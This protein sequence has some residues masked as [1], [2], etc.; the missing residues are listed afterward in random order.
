MSEKSA[1]PM[2]TP[3]PDLSHLTEDER[4]IIENVM[5]RQKKEEEKDVE[6]LKKKQEEVQVLETTI[7]K[8]A[9]E[10]REMGLTFE[11]TCEIC[12]KTKF[13]DGVGHVCHY[14]SVRCCARCGGKVTLRSNKVIWVCILCRKKQEL[15]IKTGQWV[16]SNLNNNEGQSLELS[17]SSEMFIEHSDSKQRQERRPRLEKARST[18]RESIPQ[19][20]LNSL[21]SGSGQSLPGSRRGSLK[22]S[23]SSK[24]R[25]LR[26]QY[27]QEETSQRQNVADR[28]SRRSLEVGDPMLHERGNSVSERRSPSSSD[29]RR[30]RPGSELRDDAADERHHR[31]NI[32]R[33]R[34]MQRDGARS[35]DPSLSPPTRN[36]AELRESELVRSRESSFR[37]RRR[38]TRE[39]RRE[40]IQFSDA[41]NRDEYR[42]RDRS[43]RNGSLERQPQQISESE[44]ECSRDV[45]I[46]R[47][48]S[49]N[50]SHVHDRERRRD[51]ENK[52]RRDSGKAQDL[53][54]PPHQKRFSELEHYVDEIV[55]HPEDTQ[56]R[57]IS[58][59]SRS[60]EEWRKEM[61]G[62]GSTSVSNTDT[63]GRFSSYIRKKGD[64]RNELYS[65]ELSE[66][67]RSKPHKHRR[68]KIQR[69]R[70]SSSSDDEIKTTPDDE[71][72][73]TPEWSSCDDGDVEGVIEQG[74][75]VYSRY[76]SRH[77]ETPL[78]Q[79]KD[80]AIQRGPDCYYS[81][82]DIWDDA[83]SPV[84]KKTV[85]F[86]RDSATSRQNSEELWDEQQTKDSGI[87]TSSSATLNEDNNNK[88]PIAWKSSSDG[89]RMIG[90]MILKKTL[91]EVDGSATSAAILGLKVVGGRFLESG[92]LGALV[93]KVKKGSV[94]D[95]VGH[96][97][98]GDEVLEWNGRSLQGRTYE[99]V[100]DIISESRQDHQVELRVCRPISDIGWTETMAS[101]G[102]SNQEFITLEDVSKHNLQQ[103]WRPSVTVTSPNSPETVR[104]RPHS[105][106]VGG[107]I[108][109]KLW[110]DSQASQLVVTVIC[111]AE[112]RPRVNQLT[113]NPYAKVFLLPDRSEKSKRRTKTIAN[114]NEP[115]WN[116]TFVY[117][118]LRR[119]DLKTRVLEITVWD[120]DRYGAN[121]FL[122]EVVVDLSSTP[123]DNKGQWY[124]LVSH[125]D[126]LNAQLRR[127]GMF[128]DT[129]GGSGTLAD[130][131]SPLSNV[132]SRL[133]DGD[134]S[135]F[136]DGTIVGATPWEELRHDHQRD[137]HY[138]GEDSIPSATRGRPPTII[139]SDRPPYSRRGVDYTSRSLSP[140]NRRSYSP[141]HGSAAVSQ[142]YETHSVEGIPT[143]TPSPK[144]RQL[145]PT[146]A[147][148]QKRG[149]LA[150][151]LEDMA[152]RQL[153]QRV[154]PHRRTGAGRY[155]DGEM[156]PTHSYEKQ[157]HAHPYRGSHARNS[158][159]L[160]GSHSA[161]DKR[162]SRAGQI[163]SPE[164]EGVE[165]DGSETS[166]A[167]KFSLSSAFS[168]QSKSS[169]TLSEFTSRMQGY[170]PVHPPRPGRRGPLVQST[171]IDGESDDKGDG[172]LSDTA[173]GS[174]TERGNMLEQTDRGKS[175]K[176]SKAIQFV[177]LSQKSNSTSQLSAT[178]D[179][180]RRNNSSLTGPLVSHP[181]RPLSKQT[182]GDSVA[183]SVN[184]INS[185]SSQW[186]P[187]LRLTPEGEYSTFV[188]GLG[189]GQ[190]VGRQALA[191]P[192]LGDI[193]L[194]I[195]DRKGNLEVEVIRARGLQPKPGAK[196]LP[197]PY[198]KVYLVQ[199]TKCLS[200]AKTT[201]ARR[202]LDPL[203]QEQLHF[204]E[205]YRGCV[206]QVTVWGDY[207]R[208]EKKVFMG[209]AQIM[210]DD[211]DLSNIV[212]GWYKLFHPASLV[213]LPGNRQGN[214]QCSIDSFG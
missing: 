95:T 41:G 166:S 64:P 72:K 170:G 109:L 94:A 83:G 106:V 183:S 144:K 175:T 76:K 67:T 123:L 3:L 188:E 136:D 100:F 53:K 6:I 14:C 2:V 159:N 132:S 12:L 214:P 111:A 176:G 212:I 105:P 174:I 148:F 4:K 37:N 56:S 124:F 119:S 26:R 122:G 98:P 70:S 25:E 18:D 142:R 34:Q 200:K 79:R 202:T 169:R 19:D 129:D 180:G 125:E 84:H 210:L 57:K 46:E 198:V 80:H 114:T 151:D 32:E 48:R 78:T 77:S 103:D 9:E 172:S 213:N 173:V 145:P 74:E 42:A 39:I 1:P 182:S 51:S 45:P 152:T 23:G 44:R 141:V 113:R 10:Q 49:N 85:R 139:P 116:Q 15:L 110:Y 150:L 184:A 192:N 137:E 190:L 62:F 206:L 81:N 133:S 118:S 120:Y 69:Q 43:S 52:S 102:G 193:Q 135:D 38:G 63:R 134:I 40:D 208:M 29:R 197:A 194:S 201:T 21:H 185:W 82:Q 158:N 65:S 186:M 157:L 5:Q 107:R 181:K 178:E 11:A 115:R 99:E 87:D 97:R 204:H 128:L 131:L 90:H 27:S 50:Y 177:G 31:H 86:N 71:I 112:L 59:V 93:E 138:R 203:Y 191:S 16:H 189:P 108:Q 209:V 54:E 22:R 153:K 146:P 20:N 96:L 24:S 207:G 17:P 28:H 127:Q 7:R 13:A 164:K 68:G 104:L 66:Y 165:S 58:K 187:A 195:C 154:Q 55:I 143:G 162:N 155:S 60:S 130:H 101:R 199:G 161:P 33:G 75:R 121:D 92:R 8:R 171:S 89:T 160:R 126:T 88:H 47:G 36:D 147:M 168:T 196:C 91:K 205:D 140:P 156:T 73:T 179:S 163:A 30:R 35:R 61:P 149:G 211:V 167:S 117:S